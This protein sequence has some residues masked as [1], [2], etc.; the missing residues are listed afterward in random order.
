MDG[1]FLTFEYQKKNG[2]VTK[3]QFYLIQNSTQSNK[4]ELHLEANDEEERRGGFSEL[5]PLAFNTYTEEQQ[6]EHVRKL[7]DGFYGQ[8]SNMGKA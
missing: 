2:K 7:L 6:I 4:L 1:N 5:V 3:P 8:S